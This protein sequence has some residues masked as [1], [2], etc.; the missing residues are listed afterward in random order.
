MTIEHLDLADSAL[1]LRSTVPHRLDRRLL[2]GERGAVSYTSV[3]G[4]SVDLTDSVL[5]L[6]LARPERRNAMDD[7][8]TAGLIEAIDTAGRDEDVRAIVLRS[9]GD[10]FCS[11]FDLLGRN[12]PRERRPRVGSIQRRLPSEVNRLIPLMCSV[13]VPIV[14]AVRGWAIG[15]GLNLALAADFAIAADD[16]RFWAPFV[17][18]G[19]TPDSAGTWLLPRR[20]G[21]VRAREMLE[22]DRVVTGAE[23][24]EWGMI[25]RAVPPGALDGAVDELAAHLASGPTVA[26]GLTKWLVHAGG[27]T[28]LD[29]H[30]HNEA[31]AHELAG[32]SEDARAAAGLEPD[33]APPPFAGR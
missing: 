16:A 19:F 4:V 33:A 12:V 27:Q 29:D 1:H 7:T 18:R 26:L 17:A 11:G 3:P 14:C 10:D 30:L 25:H 6:C 20:V 5:Q 28:T 2:A 9:A 23:A 8:M 13:Q 32:R 31:F 22:L 21:A 15:L 24:A